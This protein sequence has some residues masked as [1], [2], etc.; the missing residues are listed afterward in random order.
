MEAGAGAPLRRCAAERGSGAGAVAAGTTLGN[1]APKELFV[2]GGFPFLIVFWA[3]VS[4]RFSLSFSN[5]FWA[6]ELW[7]LE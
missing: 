6:V 2:H 4:G 3:I 5:V 7:R 1:Y